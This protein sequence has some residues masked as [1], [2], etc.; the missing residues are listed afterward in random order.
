MNADDPPHPLEP[1][2]LA[3]ILKKLSS[4]TRVYPWVRGGLF[5]PG[6]NATVSSAQLSPQ[7]L[8]GMTRRMWSPRTS[9]ADGG[10]SSFE[11]LLD[12]ILRARELS[13]HKL[14]SA[15][16]LTFPPTPERQAKFRLCSA[17]QSARV[18]VNLLRGRDAICVT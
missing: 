9:G 4:R 10:R 18:F 7:A 6:G 5:P 3:E 1:F 12:D 8:G 14:I 17:R 13:F 16:S 15:L 2:H 11:F